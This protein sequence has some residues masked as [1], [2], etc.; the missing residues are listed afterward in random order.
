MIRVAVHP[1][2]V[3]TVSKL[4]PAVVGQAEEKLRQITAHFGEDLT[5]KVFALWGLAFKPQTDDMREAPAIVIITELI[6][7][8]ARIQAYDPKAMDVA[9]R[10]FGLEP[11]LSYHKNNYEA[12]AGADALALVTEWTVFR[13]PDFPR[14]KQILRQPI[15]FDGRN[16]YNHLRMEEMGFKYYCIGRK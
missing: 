4:G 16:Q 13:E 1:R 15:I 8:G 12:A 9:R 10:I 14:L 6:K 7:R 3:K 11:R 5:D 2:L